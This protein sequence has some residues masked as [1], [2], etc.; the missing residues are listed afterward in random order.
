VNFL[1]LLTL[2]KITH[3]VGLIMGLGGA[4]LA[5]Y[6]IFT[7]GV[8]RPVSPYTI[9]QTEFLSHIVLAGLTILWISGCAL[10]WI[11][12]IDHPQYLTNQKLWAKIAIVVLLTLNGV[13]VHKY[14]LPILRRSIGNRLFTD[15]PRKYLG[16]MTLF[17]SIS[18]VS[19]TVPFVL[20]KASELNYVTPIWN[21][22]GVYAICVLAVWFG[23]F[24][25]M[26]SISRIQTSLQKIAAKTLQPNSMWEQTGWSGS[27]SAEP[28]WS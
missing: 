25:V 13:F 8:I 20:G 3:L 12:L 21:I 11:N 6:T 4:I 7:R 23:M 24:V 16:V 17:G 9:H 19:W 5:D 27:K 28:A 15:M 18:V 22:L 26:S 1:T 2:L 10:I 14:V